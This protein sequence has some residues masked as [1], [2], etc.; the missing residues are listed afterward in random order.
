[1]STTPRDIPLPIKRRLRQESG[2][3]CSIC[4]NPIIEYHHIKPFAEVSRHDPAD[5]M[6]LCPLHH[7][8]AT[9]SGL[10]EAEQRDSKENPINIKNGVVEGLLRTPDPAVVVEVGTNLF[11]GRGFKLVVND[12]PLLALNRADVGRLLISLDLFDDQDNLLFSIVDNEWIAGDPLPWD[13][14]FGVRVLTVRRRKGHITLEVDARKTPVALRGDLWRANQNFSISPAGLVFNGVVKNVSFAHVGLVAM[15]L[16]ADTSRDELTLRPD[17]AYTAGS[18]V[19]WP[20]K[21]ERIAKCL[22]ALEN[23]EK[24]AKERG[25]RSN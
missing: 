14:E 8:E 18:I 6:V 16:W 17:P 15:G 22:E 25:L 21:V 11:V 9:V 3:G 5:M 20:D 10:T 23:L 1:M 7:H 12:S 2:F 19:S 4:G 24:K 13:F